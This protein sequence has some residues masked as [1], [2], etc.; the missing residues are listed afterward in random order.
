MEP[1]NLPHGAPRAARLLARGE[2]P[3]GEIE[4]PGVLTTKLRV[5]RVR[6]DHIGRARLVE[7]LDEDVAQ[8][9][10]LVCT[11]AGWG[12]TTLVADWAGRTGRLV[13]WVT[14]D[15]EDNDPA[16]FWRYVA[17]ALEHAAA[18]VAERV[19]PLLGP[20]SVAS[21][22]G[23][24][25]AMVNALHDRPGELVLVLDDYHV[26][27]SA[28]V[29][30]D[31]GFLLDRLPP[32][33]RVV[34]A[35]RA[36]PPLPLHRLRAE[37][38]L[39]ELRAAD[40]RFTL[41]EATAVLRHAWS[42]DVSDPVVATLERRTEGWAA[43][44]QLAALALREEVDKEAAVAAFAGTH[45]HVLDY[46]AQEVLARLP[47]DLRTFLLEVSILRCLC[48]P[49]CAAVTGRSDGQALLEEI[50][51][52][53][54]FLFPLDGE[55]RWYRF[56]SL[57]ADV[58]LARLWASLGGWV[59]GL[60][61]RAAAW[62]EQHGWIDDAIRHAL[63]AGDPAC[64]ARL[65]E[66]HL[67]EILRRGERG[68]LE[69]RL[70]A[71]PAE[72]LHARPALSFA[73]AEIQFHLGH[74]DE[75]DRLLAQA[76]RVLASG[77]E[78]SRQELP[79]DA[80]PVRSPEAAV[81]LLR[82]RNAGVRGDVDRMAEHARAA[83]SGMSDEEY[84]ARFWA[85]WL[86]GGGADWM[87][88]RLADAEH[89]AAALLAE[90]RA[91]SPGYPLL[92]SCFSL[93]GIQR[94]RGELSAALRT[95]RESLRI[96]TDGGRS[97]P[98]H[99]AEAHGGIAQVLYQRNQLDEALEHL[100]EAFEHGRQVIWFFEPGRRLITQGWIHQAQGDPGA[101]LATLDEACRHHPHPD[102]ASLWIPAAA[103]RARLL[104]AQGRP[105]EAE[106]WV[107]ERGLSE[108]DA[109]S[110]PHERDH[111]VLARLLLARREPERAAPLLARLDALA[112]AQG[113]VD[114]LI[115]IRTL[116]ALA[117]QAAGDRRAAFACLA[118]A[119]S[120]SRAQE[121]VRVFVDE[122]PPMAALL[123]SLLRAAR[124]DSRVTMSPAGR[125]HVDRILGA[126]PHPPA[127]PAEE[128]PWTGLVDPLTARELEVLRLI[129]TGMRNREIAAEL[130]I[131][132]DTVK[133]HLSHAYDKLGVPNRT[134]AVARGR[135]LGLI[136]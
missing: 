28:S 114:S 1:E 68:I 136:P 50:E 56:H 42:L 89:A 3:A 84:G 85:R 112:E 43:G 36:D 105:E 126:F 110:Y 21:G 51:R 103:E 60:H 10:A 33:L 122:G 120:L 117:D 116:R 123:G 48:G 83:L 16:R 71:L 81:A 47:E 7:R 55:R 90:A 19:L 100:D 98:F 133:K 57:F 41:E 97:S 94:A 79:T 73:R 34:L 67:N 130:A 39:A 102:I 131:G 29:H 115:E 15:P 96:A 35:T 124:R 76:D 26:I 101:A 69:R 107:G 54:L 72:E 5:P 25:T 65:V 75:V 4:L 6:P 66:E 86:S 14:L 80:G 78:P 32:N 49:L 22:Q 27:E 93:G 106:R 61:A 95:Y 63:A 23:V 109:L 135:D 77:E 74:L 121:Y 128:P 82:A 52:A 24:V 37:G 88:G 108:D 9:L 12:K 17:G 87:A 91:G 125:Q 113:R 44:L 70:A 92:T 58:L 134:G 30:E 20:P 62:H 111:L 13:A 38:R 45:R 8:G 59:P 127:R 64:A 132:L 18:G 31:V 119:L 46:L 99:E 11:P 118:D 129:S 53:N 104:L 2:T 40:L